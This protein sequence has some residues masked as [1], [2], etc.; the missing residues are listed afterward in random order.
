MGSNAFT[1]GVKPGGL[2]TSTE[3]RILLCYL[4]SN[5]ES[6]ISREQIESVIIGEELGNYFI[7]AESLSQLVEQGLITEE[8]NFY[9]ITG[10]GRT[11]AD[12]LSGDLPKSVRET[13]VNGV[14]KAQQYEAKTAAHHTDII[15]CGEGKL[16]KCQ[17][18]DQTGPL[19][20]ME[21]FMPD[22]HTAKAVQKSFIENG[23]YVYKL[24]LASLTKDSSLAEGSMKELFK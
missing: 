12:N 6:K 18:G 22:E 1:E 5:I 4:L 9:T 23:N 16:V 19:F 20:S 13:A 8:D 21:L 15:D 17:I 24:V 10:A 7:L 2:T 3:I 14:I 11:V